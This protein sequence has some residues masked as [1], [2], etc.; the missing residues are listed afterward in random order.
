MTQPFRVAA[1]L[2][3]SLVL[4]ACTRSDLASQTKPA[5]RP[6]GSFDREY[7]LVST[8]LG[9]RGMGGE[10]DGIR[11]PTLWATT[12][13]VIRITIVNGELMVHDVVM[14]QH[15]LKSTQILEKGATASITFEAKQ[16][17]TYFCSVPGHRVAGMEGRL[18]V[19]DSPRVQSE[20]IVPEA[21]GRPV[22]LDFETGT[23][24]NWTSTGDTFEVV[25]GDTVTNQ[26]AASSSSKVPQKAG[27]QSGTFFVSSGQQDGA[28]KGTLSSSPFRVTQPYASF[29]V[30]GGA[31]GSTRV[32]LVRADNDE[33]I[34]TITGSESARLR[35]A[36]VDLKSHQ[37]QQV[38]VR[39]I[40]DETGAPSAVY[41]KPSP[42]A[43]INFDHFRFHDSRPFFPGEVTPTEMSVL[44]PMD[45]VLHAGLSPE[46]AARAMTLP[47]GFSVT[48]AA[49]EPDVVR[50]IA[51]A[52]DDRGRLWVAEARTYPVRAPEGEGKDRILIF[53]DTDGDGSLD[54]RK[55]FTEG[56]NL[57][58]GLE[59]GFGGVWV[60]A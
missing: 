46:A 5:A 43:Y 2:V 45:P 18:D 35:P 14:E 54:S 47:E 24:E 17:D 21:D 37:G 8:M 20:G 26:N 34:Y 30:A 22:N 27:G 25:K 6:A 59:I 57:V 36:V 3:L 48:L 39:L 33:V 49:A 29:L 12:G 15:G 53:E 42:W 38:F 13:E 16:S 9:Y 31:F 28:R 56:L 41:I 50:P 10:I 19:S 23:L 58:S 44:P 32:E 60:G 55:V 7:T 51:F 52:L 1:R 40:D 11:N 4:L